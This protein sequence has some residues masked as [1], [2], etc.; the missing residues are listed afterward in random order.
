MMVYWSYKA[1]RED[2]QDTDLV[3]GVRGVLS[4]FAHFF[5]R[6]RWSRLFHQIH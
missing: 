1:D 3:G 2:Y 6:T 5:T 4:T